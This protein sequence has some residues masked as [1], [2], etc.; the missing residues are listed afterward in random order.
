MLLLT[1]MPVS[2]DSVRRQDWAD[3]DVEASRP[4]LSALLQSAVPDDIFSDIR[5][6]TLY[7]MSGLS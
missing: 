6:T 2:S 1:C 3:E 4:F 7:Y 5:F